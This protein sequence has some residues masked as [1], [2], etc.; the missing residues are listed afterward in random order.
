MQ[1]DHGIL[2][3]MGGYAVVDIAGTVA[4]GYVIAQYA[5]VPVVPTIVGAFVLGEVV[6]WMFGINTPLLNTAGLMR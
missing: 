5:E 1:F 6:H 4:I 2:G 3:R